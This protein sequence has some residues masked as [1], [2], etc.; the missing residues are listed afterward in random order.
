MK[1]TKYI[2]SDSSHPHIALF[3]NNGGHLSLGYEYGVESI[4]CASDEGGMIWNGKMKYASLEALLQD[5]E[6][7]IKKWAEENW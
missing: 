3:L 2:K 1:N 5:A 6:E 4:A 7:G